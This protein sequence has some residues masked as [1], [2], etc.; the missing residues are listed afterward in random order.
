[1]ISTK[2]VVASSDHRMVCT[3][4]AAFFE[5]GLHLGHGG[6]V[7]QAW[8]FAVQGFLNL[9]AKPLVVAGFLLFGVE[10]GN[11]GGQRDDS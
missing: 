7:R 3:G 10:Q 1:M 8:L 9:G 6:I 11:D 5:H 4:F 2:S